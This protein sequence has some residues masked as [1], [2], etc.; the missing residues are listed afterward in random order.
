MLN[1]S[2]LLLS[3]HKNHY[4][5]ANK[6]I[7]CL[8]KYAQAASPTMQYH[9]LKHFYKHMETISRGIIKYTNFSSVVEKTN[10]PTSFILQ[11]WDHPLINTS[12]SLLNFHSVW[13]TSVTN[14][15]YPTY[16]TSSSISSLPYHLCHKSSS[17]ISAHLLNTINF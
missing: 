4:L 15:S 14:S 7:D 17:S 2:Y 3:L 16:W 1:S 11:T 8:L 5:P 10:C 6:Q 9:F 13:I 12:N